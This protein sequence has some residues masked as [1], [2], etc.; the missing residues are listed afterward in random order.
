MRRILWTV[1]ILPL[2][3]QLSASAS[4][5]SSM[6]KVRLITGKVDTVKAASSDQSSKSAAVP[7]RKRYRRSSVRHVPWSVLQRRYPGS[8]VTRGNGGR[9]L[10]ALTFDD[11]PDPRY[12]PKVL[13]ILAKHHTRATFFVLGS[14]AAKYPELVKR[15]VREGHLVGNHSYSHAL[16][17]K[18]SLASYRKQI[19]RTDQLL[20]RLTGYRPRFIRPPYGEILPRQVEW[21]REHG[22]IVVNWDVD[23]VDWTSIGSDKIMANIRKTLQ[24]G[25]IILQ[26][27]G[28][29]DSQ[30]LSGTVNA[31]PKLIRY[32]K[33][34]GY[35]A[36]TVDEL[37]GQRGL[38][39]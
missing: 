9:K 32:L 23:S 12:T 26:H 21:S 18:S 24:P 1:V 33:A 3:L 29:G 34:K 25:S 30:D 14:R 19:E 31:V 28:G 4:H 11:V 20:A 38:R 22:Y 16:F 15:M 39:G 7:R 35:Q 36:V 37:L 27:A 13:D 17:A 10:V 5:T 8:F 6:Y 2:L